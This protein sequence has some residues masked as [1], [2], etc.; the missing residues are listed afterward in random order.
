MKGNQPNNPIFLSTFS[1]LFVLFIF[2][3]E[4]TQ[5]SISCCPLFGLFWCIKYLNFWPKATVQTAHYTFLESRNPEVTKNLYYVL[6]TH[7][8]QN[9]HFFRHQLMD[10]QVS[11]FVS[12]IFRTLF[13]IALLIVC[14]DKINQSCNHYIQC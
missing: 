4:T 3:F 1:T 7:W 9:T 5:N 14:Y 10:Y 13:V 2:E 12:I 6:S 11:S 8:S